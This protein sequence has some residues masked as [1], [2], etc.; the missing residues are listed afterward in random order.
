MD[1]GVVERVYF[2][3]VEFFVCNTL[4]LVGE[5]SASL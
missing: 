1:T 4:L 2:E 3:V 5:A